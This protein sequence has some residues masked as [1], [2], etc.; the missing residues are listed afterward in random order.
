MQQRIP[1]AEHLQRFTRALICRHCPYRRPH[2]GEWNPEAGR[3][4]E[5]R[6]P[7]FLHLPVL[8]AMARQLDPMI[9]DRR[10]VLRKAVMSMIPGQSGKA[11]VLRKNGLRLIDRVEEM[12]PK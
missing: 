2:T 8:R 5:Q 3:P 12:F 10:G 1:T 7:L 4:C 11:Q 9:C 6:C